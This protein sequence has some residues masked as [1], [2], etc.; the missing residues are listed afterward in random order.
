[1]TWNTA[2]MPS[3]R[4]RPALLALSG[5]ALAAAGAGTGVAASPAGAAA[6]C[7]VPAPT[8]A[9]PTY[10]DTTRAGGEPQVA[11]LAN[12]R[13]LYSA[14]AGTTHFFAPESATLGTTIFADNYTGQTYVWTSDDHGATW[15]FRPRAVPTQGSGDVPL[16]GFSDPEVAQ[17]S[18]GTVYFSEI[19]LANVAVFASKDNGA[20]YALKKLNGLTLT[21][22]QWMEGDRPGEFYIAANSFGGD[23]APVS[24]TPLRHY[25]AKSKDGGATYSASVVDE[26]GGSGLGDLEVDKSSGTLYEAHYNGGSSSKAPL[27]VAAFRDARNGTL[28]KPDLGK[29]ADGVAMLAHWP[30]VRTDKLGNLYITW[31]ESGRGARPAGVYYSASADGGRTWLSPVRLDADDRTDI[32]P[33]LAVGDTGRVAVAWLEADVK[34]PNENAE[35]P[36]T[37][38]WRVVAAETTS[39]LGCAGGAPVFASAVATPDA[40]H[41]GTICQG[42]TTCQAQ[43][44]D[45]RLGDYFAIGVDDTGAAY[46]GV[47]DTRKDAPVSLPLF[48]R[49]SGGP[50]LLETGQQPQTAVPEAPYAVGLPL[51]A[52]A[53]GAGLLAAVALRR[54]RRAAR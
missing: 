3:R 37:H 27:Y 47:S 39:G 18:A 41:T 14:H 17:D 28:T 46:V 31:D 54:R 19:N 50:S 49:Q 10:V 32:W 53:G 36:G 2:G 15:Q 33:W 38:G 52:L 9:P 12:G 20:T 35:T 24:T 48:V 44:I 11:T 34:L 25:L 42:G 13:L 26:D 16:T 29:V 7:A 4:S 43:A 21:D 45:R 23:T 22:R 40:I 1:V 6:S 5:L 8:F 30:S 51:A